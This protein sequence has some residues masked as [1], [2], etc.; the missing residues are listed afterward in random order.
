MAMLSETQVKTLLS[1]AAADALE[2]V[3]NGDGGPF[4]ALI[5]KNDQVISLGHN[6]VFLFTDPSAHAEIVAIRKACLT[7]RQLFLDDCTL[8]STCEPCPMCLS[9]A[10]WARIPRIYF[11]S[12]RQEAE[13]IGFIDKHIYQALQN[14]ISGEIDLQQVDSPDCPPLFRFWEESKQKRPY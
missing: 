3:K 5:Y 7:L 9:A 8:I 2:G 14:G 11:S 10:F 12:T 4:G 13:E 1:L 6:S